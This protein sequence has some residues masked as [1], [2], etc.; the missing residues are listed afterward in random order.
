M[1]RPLTPGANR[2]K[3]APPAN[4][5]VVVFGLD[6]KVQLTRVKVFDLSELATNPA[7]QPIWHLVAESNSVSLKGFVYGERIKGM[8]SY[9]KDSRPLALQ[10]AVAYRLVIE[11]GSKKGQH[12]F[13]LGKMNNDPSPTRQ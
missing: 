5:P 12:E 9:V 1:S 6:R 10:P 3:F 8:Q 7:A 2:A 13:S 11:S 4:T